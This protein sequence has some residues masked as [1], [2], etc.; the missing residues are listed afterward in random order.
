[1]VRALKLGGRIALVEYRAEDTGVPIKTL[2]K[3]SERQA[4]REMEAIV[5]FVVTML[6]GKGP[7]DYAECVL[8][9]GS[10]SQQCDSLKK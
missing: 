8:F 6:Q 7:A 5:E 9:W 3:M 4:R 1:M 2:H 10:T